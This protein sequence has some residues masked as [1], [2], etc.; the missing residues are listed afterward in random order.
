MLLKRF[1]TF[2]TGDVEELAQKLEHAANGRIHKAEFPS[3]TTA[4]WCNSIERPT[5]PLFM[6]KSDA[7]L[8][9]EYQPA[10]YLRIVFQ[11]RKASRVILQGT[12]I[13]TG[14][15]TVG[16]VIPEAVQIRKLDPDGHSSLFFRIDPEDLRRN[17]DAL[18]GET[19]SGHVQFMQPTESNQNFSRYVR[20]AAFQAAHELDALDPRFHDSLIKELH[21][22]TLLR[23]LIHLPHNHSHRLAASSQAPSRSQLSR[24]EDFIAENYGKPIDVI[25]IA[26]A[27]GA[28]VRSVFRHF[29][30]VH[31]ESP[32]FYLKRLRLE[33]A[34][35]M[36]ADSY[37]TR[38]VTEI[39]LLCGFLSLGHF[40]RAYKQRFGELPSETAARR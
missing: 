22:L 19:I 34:R 37:E 14:P 20:D 6:L 38:S 29:Q 35:A 16:Y 2:Q 1:P 4:Y 5:L 21:A 36:L 39:A 12:E 40:A 24:A 11:T 7:S 8:D 3:R 32:H 26:A 28:S 25:G 17:L 30:Q 27:T 18:C 23:L 9:V 10:D 13:D 15:Q 31:G 33:R